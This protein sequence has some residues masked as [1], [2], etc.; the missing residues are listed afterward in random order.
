M[1]RAYAAG[2]ALL[3]GV[4]FV[5]ALVLSVGYTRHVQHQSDQRWCPLLTIVDRPNPARAP[6]T[7]DQVQARQTLHQLRLDLGCGGP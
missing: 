6:Q 1:K 5:G 4:L 3:V 7:P 2:M